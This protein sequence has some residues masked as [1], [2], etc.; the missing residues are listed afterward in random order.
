MPKKKDPLIAVIAFFEQAPLLVAE[1]VLALAKEVVRRRQP[2]TEKVAR[3]PKGKKV[4]ALHEIG[5]EAAG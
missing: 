4:R 5:G 2:V 3:K 1:S